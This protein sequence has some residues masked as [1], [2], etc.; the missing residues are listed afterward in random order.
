[1]EGHPPDEH[2]VNHHAQRVIVG[3]RIEFIA[4]HAGCLLV[5]HVSGRAEHHAGL[6]VRGGLAQLGNAEIDDLDLELPIAAPSQE[7][8]I[9]LEVTMDDAQLV[10]SVQPLRRLLQNFRHFGDRERPAPLEHVAKRFAFQKLHGDVRRAII[11]LAR[12]VNGDHVRVADAP[13]GTRLVLKAQQEIGVVEKLAV[14]NLERHGAIAH[15]NLLGEENRAHAAL[16][17]GGGQGEIGG[18]APRQAAPR[19][20]WLERPDERRRAD[21]TQSHPSKFAG[22]CGRFSWAPGQLSCGADSSKNIAI[23]R[24]DGATYRSSGRRGREGIV[25]PAL[26]WAQKRGTGVPPVIGHGR[27]GHSTSANARRCTAN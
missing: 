14:Q 6:R 19:S 9:G 25:T 24:I 8:V 26:R 16:H 13:R 5:G 10:R 15:P 22:K 11:R 1:M 4:G 21:K 3:A 17:P 27:D 12:F 23:K 20:P 2:F 18:R 7:N